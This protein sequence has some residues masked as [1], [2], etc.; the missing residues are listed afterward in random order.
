MERDNEFEKRIGKKLQSDLPAGT[1]DASENTDERARRHMQRSANKPAQKQSIKTSIGKRW[2]LRGAVVVAAVAIFVTSFSFIVYKLPLLQ[3]KADTIYDTGGHLNNINYKTPSG[4]FINAYNGFGL[5]VL[6][7]L[8]KGKQNVFLS[9]ASLYLALGMTYNGANGQTASDFEKV[10]STA[11]GN[12][13]GFDQDCLALQSMMTSSSR[14]KF[15]NSIWLRD[16]FSKKMNG[17]FLE[18]NK[19]FFGST[20]CTLNFSSPDAPTVINRWVKNHTGNRIDPKFKQFDANTMINIINTVY[21]KSDWKKQF[22]GQNTRDGGF[23]TPSGSKTVKLMYGEYTRYFENEFLQGI[24]LPYDDN[25]SS[26]MVLLPKTN[27]DDL[28]GKMTSED[29]TAYVKDNMNSRTK[30]K[31]TLPRVNLSY[32]ASLDDTLKTLGLK[33]AFDSDRADFSGMAK[34]NSGLYISQVTH[35]TYLAID[36]KGTEAAA[37]TAVQM[38][39]SAPPLK[40]NTMVVDHPFLTAIV[41][42]ET[43]AMLFIG[44]VTDPSVSQ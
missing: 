15:A 23:K 31:L 27:L 10:L 40:E 37:A 38:A 26:M 35:M 20:I 5:N 7:R 33:T 34:P 30:A 3:A 42:N 29:L 41:N 4:D 36:E 8:Y 32:E 24:I 39:G 16:S 6:G 11:S 1:H 19:H 18:R 25:K 44:I 9:P 12:I 14:F 13:E 22:D 2:A 28:L 21:F 43:G 17:S